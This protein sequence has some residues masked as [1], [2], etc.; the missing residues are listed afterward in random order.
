MNDI[1]QWLLVYAVVLWCLM[2]L[3]QK[4]A[5]QSMWQ[6]QAKV[7]YFFEIRKASWS[8]RLGRFL[9]PAVAIPQGCQSHCSS[10]RNCA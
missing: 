9:R 6:W 2:R 1:L 10:C 3:M 4:Y 5:S 7:S 8:R